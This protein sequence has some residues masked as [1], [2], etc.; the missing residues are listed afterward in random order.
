MLYPPP[1]R[2]VLRVNGVVSALAGVAVLLTGPSLAT[3]AGLSPAVVAGAGALMLAF[4]AVSA[5]V[6]ALRGLD[7]RRVLPLALTELAWV[8]VSLGALVLAPHEMTA[9]GRALL[10]SIAVIAAWFAMAELRAARKL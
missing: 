1:A 4:G 3:A 7:S 9:F 5:L 10:G 2:L 6:S 8:A